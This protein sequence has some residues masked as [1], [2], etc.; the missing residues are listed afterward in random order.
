MRVAGAAANEYYVVLGRGVQRIGLVTADLIRFTDA[1]DNRDIVTVAPDVIGA[2][3]IVDTLGVSTFPERGGV[4]GEAIVCARW[5][6]GAAGAETSVMVGNSMPAAVSDSMMPALPAAGTRGWS[7][8]FS[9]PH[10]C[11]KEVHS[12]YAASAPT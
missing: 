8:T 5:R 4:S 10:Y 11:H 3:P 1:Q 12:E 2:V 6:F 7:T 9:P